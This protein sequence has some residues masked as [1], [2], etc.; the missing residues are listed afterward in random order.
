M[1][2]TTFA[3]AAPLVD[4]VVTVTERELSVAVS[5]LARRCGA[6]VEGA[7]ATALAAVLAGKVQGRAIVVPVCGRNIDPTVHAAVL[8]AT[9]V[10]A[11]LVENLGRAA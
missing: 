5:V 2:A 6:V 9:P 3:L 8:A 7:G 10:P 11:P 4:D 1:G